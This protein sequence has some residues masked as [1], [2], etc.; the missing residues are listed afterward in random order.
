MRIILDPGHGGKFTGAR[1]LGGFWEKDVTLDICLQAEVI[2]Q[3]MGYEV[4]L[5]RQEDVELAKHKSADLRKRLKQVIKNSVFVSLHVLADVEADENRDICPR[6]DQIWYPEN[7]EESKLLA[8]SL[9]RRIRQ[10]FPVEPLKGLASTDRIFVLRE[11]GVPSA[12]VEIGSL[13]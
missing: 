9:D 10:S 12:L 2:L 1:I 8:T 4:V 6:G 5:T 7:S 3:E 11:S 13:S